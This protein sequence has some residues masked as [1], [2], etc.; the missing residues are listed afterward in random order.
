MNCPKRPKE[1]KWFALISDRSDTTCCELLLC[2]HRLKNKHSLCLRE[3]TLRARV[4]LEFA[5]SEL[6]NSRINQMRKK[7]TTALESFH[8]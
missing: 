1:G 5:V 7:T 3:I 4:A 8:L 2:N 6:N